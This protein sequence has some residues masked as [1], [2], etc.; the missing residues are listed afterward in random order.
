MYT[1]PPF[2]VEHIFP[3]LLFM[4]SKW[5][6]LGKALSL[7]EDRL[8][9]IFTNNETDEACLNVMLEH[10]M[11]RSDLKHSWEEVREAKRKVEEKDGGTEELEPTSQRS[12]EGTNIITSETIFLIVVICLQYMYNGPWH[13]CT[14]IKP[15][16]CC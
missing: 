15:M 6:A 3:T 2:T 9:E 7:D 5:Q 1:D 14:K 4:A 11:K 16:N 13:R 12:Q 10:Y 8:D